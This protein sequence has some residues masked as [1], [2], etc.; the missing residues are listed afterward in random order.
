MSFFRVFF[1]NLVG[2]RFGQRWGLRGPGGRTL[3]EPG[4]TQAPILKGRDV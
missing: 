1:D 4:P 3:G 2:S